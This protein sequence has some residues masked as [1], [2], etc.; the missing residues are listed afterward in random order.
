MYASFAFPGMKY[1]ITI[2][3]KINGDAKRFRISSGRAV[4]GFTGNKTE[5]H[6]N[7]FAGR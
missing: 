7:G 1:T 5:K 4:N 3:E 2:K 6:N